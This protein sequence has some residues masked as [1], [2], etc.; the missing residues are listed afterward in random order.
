MISVNMKSGTM[1]VVF[2][3]ISLVFYYFFAEH[4]SISVYIGF[5]KC[6]YM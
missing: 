5:V 1:N 3:A 4:I 2:M 6:K